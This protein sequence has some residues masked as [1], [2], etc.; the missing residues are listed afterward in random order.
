MKIEQSGNIIKKRTWFGVGPI[1]YQQQFVLE[2]AKGRRTERQSVTVTAREPEALGVHTSVVRD[3]AACLE[4]ARLMD[5][6]AWDA[7]NDIQFLEYASVADDQRN[8]AVRAKR[9]LR[10]KG[11]V[12]RGM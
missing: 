6:R 8:L 9:E 1:R 5:A 7:Q 10:Q 12:I 11:I 3:I 4:V 2:H